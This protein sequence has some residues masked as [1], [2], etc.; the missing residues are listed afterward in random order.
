M[1]IQSDCSNIRINLKGQSENLCVCAS[2]VYLWIWTNICVCEQWRWQKEEYL[3]FFVKPLGVRRLIS[4]LVIVLSTWIGHSFIAQR[5]MTSS[6]FAGTHGVW[7]WEVSLTLKPYSWYILELNCIG[8]CRR[9]TVVKTTNFFPNLKIHWWV[10]MVV[11][12][13]LP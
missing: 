9:K 4:C 2:L 11:I 7:L 10:E 3:M 13:V 12:I 6:A 5:H 8:N 1:W